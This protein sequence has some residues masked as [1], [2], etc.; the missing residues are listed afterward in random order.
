MHCTTVV[1][2]LVQI[3][4]CVAAT[5]LGVSFPS[6]HTSSSCAFRSSSRCVAGVSAPLFWIKIL[7]DESL[8]HLCP[9]PLS[10]TPQGL[11]SQNL[12]LRCATATSASLRSRLSI[13]S[14]HRTAQSAQ[15]LRVLTA[16]PPPASQGCGQFMKEGHTWCGESRP[17]PILF[18]DDNWNH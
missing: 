3:L 9:K 13:T 6:T 5:K 15:G 2:M 7:N 18:G 11:I 4:A 1:T 17:V 10:Q 8:A 14:P 16:Q 12:N